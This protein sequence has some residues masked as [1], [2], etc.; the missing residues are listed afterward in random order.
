MVT[1][2]LDFVCVFVRLPKEYSVGHNRRSS[3]LSIVFPWTTPHHPPSLF[4]Q[5]FVHSCTISCYVVRNA[6]GEGKMQNMIRTILIWKFFLSFSWPRSKFWFSLS[7]ERR[8]W[9]AIARSGQTSLSMPSNLFGSC[10]LEPYLDIV[11]TP[12]CH[13]SAFQDL[14]HVCPTKH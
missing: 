7:T 3:R 6:H 1:P 12:M 4:S 8:F 2:D 11:S 13:H 10:V 5:C 9:A 14:L